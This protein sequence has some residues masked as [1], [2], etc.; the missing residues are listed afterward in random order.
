M[1]KYYYELLSFISFA[2]DIFISKEV[3]FNSLQWN[4]AKIDAVITDLLDNKYI[5]EYIFDGIIKYK[6]NFK[7]N[8]FI[9]KFDKP[10]NENVINKNN[11]DKTNKFMNILSKI[12]Q[13][14]EQVV[15]I[16]VNLISFL[17]KK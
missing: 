1:E 14:L 16:V 13:K 7:G 12:L 15:S 11:K 8:E 4:Y 6:V 3:I 10:N 2:P 9:K 5:D 17:P